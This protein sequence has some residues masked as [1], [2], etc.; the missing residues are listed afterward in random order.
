MKRKRSLYSLPMIA[1]LN[2]ARGFQSVRDAMSAAQ[3]S[4][5]CGQPAPEAGK[6]NM[7]NLSLEIFSAYEIIILLS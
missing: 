1:Q 6:H 7:L 3:K 5:D 4:E 2:K